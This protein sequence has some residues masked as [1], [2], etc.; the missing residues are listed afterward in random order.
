MKTLS[1]EGFAQK[2]RAFITFLK[3]AGIPSGRSERLAT[4][5]ERL[6]HPESVGEFVGIERGG[7]V[8]SVA[9]SSVGTGGSGGTIFVFKGTNGVEIRGSVE[10]HTGRK[11]KK[12]R[13]GVTRSRK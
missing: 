12:R 9:T 6:A 4:R 10:S 1:K 7:K 8:Y 2:R 5:F 11:G 13:A 3:K